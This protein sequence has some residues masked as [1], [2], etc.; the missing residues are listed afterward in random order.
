MEEKNMTQHY[1]GTTDTRDRV[2]WLWTK[3]SANPSEWMQEDGDINARVL[4][5]HAHAAAGLARRIVTETGIEYAKEMEK[6]YDKG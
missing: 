4:F 3:D 6:H 2:E 5:A 1:A